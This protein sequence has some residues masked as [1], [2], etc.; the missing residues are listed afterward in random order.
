MVLFLN[1]AVLYVLH[2]VKQGG[3]I[4][5]FDQFCGFTP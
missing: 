5:K 2:S 4:I 3:P 1:L